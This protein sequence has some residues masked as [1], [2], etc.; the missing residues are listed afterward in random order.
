MSTVEVYLPEKGHEV[1]QNEMQLD[2]QRAQLKYQV[3]VSSNRYKSIN[4]ALIGTSFEQIVE[5]HR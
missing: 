3:D 5:I 2:L 4:E 1:F